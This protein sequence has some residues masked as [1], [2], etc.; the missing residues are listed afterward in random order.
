MIYDQ[1]SLK[2]SPLEPLALAKVRNLF[3]TGGALRIDL[4][5]REYV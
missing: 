2:I 4:L 3:Y 5:V 1:K